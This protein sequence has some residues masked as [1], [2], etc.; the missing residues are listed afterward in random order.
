MPVVQL[1]GE[2]IMKKEYKGN[3]VMIMC[4]S[5]CN[6]R[7]KH[8]YIGY[9]GN[10]S[11]KDLYDLS[12]NLTKKY[13]VRLNGTEIILHQDFF[14]TLKLIGQ[15]KIITNGLEIHRNPSV[16][17]K[18]KA[19]GINWV[20]MSYHFGIH[21]T[22]SRVSKNIILDNIKLLKENGFITEIFTTISQKNYNDIIEFAKEAYKLGVNYI[23]FTNYLRIGNAINLSNDN[24]L[25]DEEIQTFF[26]KLNEARKMF[27]KD[28][29]YIRRCARLEMM[30]IQTNVILIALQEETWQL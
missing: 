26:K 6:T 28:A 29:L 19:N 30:N 7:C 9:S 18:L 12:E 1:K 8:C 25:S 4:C 2:H 23:K 10:F 27:S 21:E 14:P 17:E 5:D 24:V 3:C 20:A 22:I 15:D 13:I 16:L 11:G